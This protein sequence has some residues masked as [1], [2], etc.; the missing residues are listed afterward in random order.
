MNCP[1]P[2]DRYWRGALRQG[3]DGNRA[4]RCGVGIFAYDIHDQTPGTTRNG[5]ILLAPNLVGNR[6]SSHCGPGLELP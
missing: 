6:L 1:H 5:N 3:K 2:P 4:P